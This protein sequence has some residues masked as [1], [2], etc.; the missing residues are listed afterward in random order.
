MCLL[1]FKGGWQK[2]LSEKVVSLHEPVKPPGNPRGRVERWKSLLMQL[3]L[4][5]VRQTEKE[6]KKEGINLA[7]DMTSIETKNAFDNKH[8]LGL[9]QP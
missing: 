6:R 2:K 3:K 5:N 8:E 4:L 7:N 9:L 1:R